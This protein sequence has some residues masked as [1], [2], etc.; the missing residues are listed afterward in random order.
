MISFFAT[1]APTRP[2]P[3]G[4]CSSRTPCATFVHR[5]LFL[6][7]TSQMLQRS[8]P[9][10]SR[11]MPALSAKHGIQILRGANLGRIVEN[12]AGDASVAII[13]GPAE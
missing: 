6:E 11:A 9:T 5:R 3:I 2:W 7:S 8:A 12:Y 1:A 10:R 13:A 4:I